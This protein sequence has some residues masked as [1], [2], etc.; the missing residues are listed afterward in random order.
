MKNYPHTSPSTHD[1]VDAGVLPGAPPLSC[2]IPTLVQ[3]FITL[4][5]LL[6]I[7]LPASTPSSPPPASPL[8]RLVPPPSL[9]CGLLSYGPSTSHCFP[10]PP[11][12]PSPA[13]QHRVALLSAS[14]LP[15]LT[16]HCSSLGSLD[17]F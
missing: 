16:F 13:P 4:I 15:R 10:P 11:T 14:F 8:L 17:L 7:T 1:S 2:S 6:P 12:P 3:L 5:H 9:P